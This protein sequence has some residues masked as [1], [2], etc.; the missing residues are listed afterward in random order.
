M[1]ELEEKEKIQSPELKKEITNKLLNLQTNLK[2][3]KNDDNFVLKNSQIK[4]KNF[5]NN[6]NSNLKI[7]NT[8]STT[9]LKNYL[10]KENSHCN[11]YAE[12]KGFE[13]NK[14]NEPEKNNN[15]ILKNNKKLKNLELK[16]LDSLEVETNI[17]LSNENINSYHPKSSNEDKQ[18]NTISNESDQNNLPIKKASYN[19]V[20]PFSHDDINKHKDNLNSLRITNLNYVKV[21]QN[22]K[23][24]TYIKGNSDNIFE[25]DNNSEALNQNLSKNYNS[26]RAQN[27]DLKYIS[28]E[29]LKDSLESLNNNKHKHNKENEDPYVNIQIEVLSDSNTINN[30][31]HQNCKIKIV[32]YETYNNDNPENKENQNFI[33]KSEENVIYR[34]NTNDTNLPNSNTLPLNE[35][36]IQQIPEK[37]KKTLL[38]YDINNPQIPSD[39]L[40]EIHLSLSEEESKIPSV[41]GYMKNQQDINEQM[42]AILVDWIIEV[43][44]KF[45]LKEETLFLCIYI[46]DKYLKNEIIP[47]SKL[48]L[49][50]VASI[51]ISCKQEE[52]YSPSIRDYVFIT[53][54]AYSKEEIFEMEYEILKVMEFNTV[55]P[56]SLRFF[57]LIAMDFK[58]DS[59][60]FNF[61]LYL[62]ELYL[63]DYRMTKYFPS[64]IAC[65][66]AYIV[67]KFFKLPNYTK[68]Y[69]CWNRN[70]N[71]PSLIK[72]CAR[73][74]CFLVDNINGS[75]LKATKKKFSQDKYDAVSLI[76]FC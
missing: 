46:I 21:I 18:Q 26:N 40:N 5:L 59:R 56:S 73:E 32:N 55:M 17:S 37:L 71:S 53:D 75:S 12:K 58:F 33:N 76:D 61:G 66:A 42:R 74:V 45:N 35:G 63:I 41:F 11:V 69:H 29:N 67:M 16:D 3:N 60:Q 34:E 39:Y 68:I 62:L 48:Q 44:T 14:E 57:E 38:E 10:Y 65:T 31:I 19:E 13:E 47:R 64:V 6:K 52:I 50:G 70:T 1:K 28:I 8:S 43:H 27:N 23:K 4:I 2:I 72:D 36:E 51:M 7:R 9:K 24:F 15:K 49:L 30:E 25:F 54:N 20:T 22:E